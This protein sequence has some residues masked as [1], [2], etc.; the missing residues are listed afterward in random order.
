[1]NSKADPKMCVIIV[2][3]LIT[4]LGSQAR[5]DFIFGTPTNLGPTVN[6]SAVEAEPSISADGLLLFFNGDRSGGLGGWDIWLSTRPTTEDEWAVPENLGLTINSSGN[7]YGASMTADGLTLVFGSNRS[8]GYGRSD[9]YM[10]TRETTEDPWGIPMN[11][12][13]TLNTSGGDGARISADGL[14]LIIVSGRPGDLGGG[15]FWVSTRA[16]TDD[17]WGDPVHLGPP[18]NSAFGE[19]YPCI[20]PDGLAL[21]FS[22]A[23]FASPRPSGFGDSDIWMATRTTID[24]EWG[25]PVNLGPS[26]NTVYTER[27]PSL[28]ADGSM[29]YFASNQSGTVGG[30]RL[31]LWHVPIIPIVDLNADGIVDSADMCIL[32]DNWGTDEPLCDIGPMPW[33]DGIVDVEDLVVLAEHL[34]EDFSGIDDGL[35]EI[36]IDRR[37]SASSDDAEEALNAG[38]TNWNDSTDLEIVDDN[39]DNGGG[40][41]IGMTF[42]D[43]DIAPGE[44]ISN[45]YIE[46]T[47]DETRNG[48]ADAYF[49]I[50]AHLTPNSDGFIEPYLMSDRP[51][52]EV[53]VSW[54]PDPWNAVRQRI[55]SVDIAPIIQELIDQEGWA[56]G[57]AVEIIIGADP[58]KP[59]FSGVR[60]AESYD[61]SSSNA[62]LL[63]IEIAV[64]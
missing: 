32:V 23:S 22:S 33:G 54:E 30:A 53:K 21:F 19:E 62:P 31:D 14:M 24:A 36:V 44:V 55:Q 50:W 2:L 25:E 1:M 9:I 20:S 38:Y 15:D 43:I 6:S 49:L 13:P 41:L 58:S 34:F 56:V 16:M 12:G 17:P 27:A 39:T 5:A 64:P 42:R 61:G 4:S 46:F 8:G 51:K 18:V 60:V 52:T 45:A 10:A 63:H 11:L 35:N 47:C 57:N 7:E 48:T 29:L 28:S 40:Q 26:V 59:A 37:I 3:A